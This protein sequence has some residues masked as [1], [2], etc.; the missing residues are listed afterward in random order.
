MADKQFTVEKRGGEWQVILKDVFSVGK[1]VVDA[2]TGESKF[3]PSQ[4]T[5]FSAAEMRSIASL[6]QTWTDS[7]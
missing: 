1:I 6:V 3:T 7:L 4:G 2:K 5:S